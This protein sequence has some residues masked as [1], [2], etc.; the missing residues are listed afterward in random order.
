MDVAQSEAKADPD[1]PEILA[2]Q[3]EEL[4]KQC[5]MLV[6]SNKDLEAEMAENGHDAMLREAVGENVVLIAKRRGLI[7]DLVKHLP[8][9]HALSAAAAEE[10]EAEDATMHD[11]AVATEGEGVHL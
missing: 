6:R 2:K 10:E 7:A 4:Q 11:A 3:I 5:N 8:P 9:G 1:H